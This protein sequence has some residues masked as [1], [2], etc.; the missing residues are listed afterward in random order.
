MT[1]T[2][3]L[4]ATRNSSRRFQETLD[5]LMGFGYSYFQA[6]EAALNE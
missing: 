1:K 2:T 4:D 6:Y 3:D 5:R